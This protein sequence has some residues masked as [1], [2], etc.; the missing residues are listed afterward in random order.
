M[1]KPDTLILASHNAGKVREFQRLLGPTGVTLLAHTG[2]IAEETGQTYY[3]NAAIKAVSVAQA[4]GGVALADDSG[5]E[6]DALGGAPGVYSARFVGNDPWKNTREILLRLLETPSSQR[7]ARM[8]AVLCVAWPDGQTVYTEG[9]LEGTILGWPRGPFG[10]GMDPV[11]S[12]DG[13]HSLAEMDENE[14][15]RISHRGMA[16]R[17]LLE[18]WS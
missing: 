8:R 2:P 9:V 14:K 12:V 13:T 3:E 16:L 18:L 15:N 1:T 11:F 10:F 17:R 5:I 6:V 4:T 7:T